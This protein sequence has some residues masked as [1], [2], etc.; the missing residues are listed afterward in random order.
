M[1]SESE[2]HEN[3]EENG[4]RCVGCRKDLY[5]GDDVWK[6]EQ[7]VLGP[8]SAVPLEAERLF[9]SRKCLA[10]FFRDD[11]DIGPIEKRPRRIP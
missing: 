7:A 4:T 5:L 1:L 10:D 8:R 11:H 3:S 9:C 6:T 2:D